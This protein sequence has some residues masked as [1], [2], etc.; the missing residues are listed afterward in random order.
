MESILGQL[1]KQVV[2]LWLQ[3]PSGFCLVERSTSAQV[4]A[5][6]TAVWEEPSQPK[7]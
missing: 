5:Y 2:A 6:V 3:L 1:V 7:K 4:V